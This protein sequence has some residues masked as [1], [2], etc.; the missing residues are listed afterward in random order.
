MKED[1]PVIIIMS[2]LDKLPIT[3][4]EEIQTDYKK[5]KKGGISLDECFERQREL[6][7]LQIEKIKKEQEMKFEKNKRA[8]AIFEKIKAR[9]L[10]KVKKKEREA[11]NLQSDNDSNTKKDSVP[12]AKVDV[13]AEESKSSQNQN[14][15][16]ATYNCEECEKNGKSFNSNVL[17]LYENHIHMKHSN[18]KPFKCE[19]DKCGYTTHKKGNLNKH[20]TIHKEWTLELEL[21]F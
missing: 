2:V 8:E 14:K 15:P 11:N 21:S 3:F 7:L 12:D 6:S 9:S 17:K 13:K 4:W 1:Q 19:Q 18:Y 5:Y 16:S 10:E 20:L